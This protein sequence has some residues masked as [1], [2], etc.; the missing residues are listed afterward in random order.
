[1]YGSDLFPLKIITEVITYS[2]M[3]FSLP[4]RYFSIIVKRDFIGYCYFII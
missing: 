2:E 1:M 3:A 4:L